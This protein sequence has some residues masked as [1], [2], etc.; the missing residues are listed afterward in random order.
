MLP[1]LR[2]Q[3][4]QFFREWNTAALNSHEDNLAAGFVALG[5]FVRYARQGALDGLGV[6]DDGGIRHGEKL[7]I[8]NSKV[9]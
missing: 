4:A 3:A 9:Q 1:D 6:Q 5:D 2:E 8:P 7:Q